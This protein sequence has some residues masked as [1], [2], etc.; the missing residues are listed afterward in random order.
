MP[1]WI[2]LILSLFMLAM[3]VAGIAYAALHGF[4]ALNGIAEIGSRLGKPLSELADVP[5]GADA[6]EPLAPPTFTQPLNSTIS[7][8]DD[9]QVDVIRR[10]NAKRERHARAWARWSRFNR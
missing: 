6:R 8:Y 5:Q 2:W 4:R 7:R 1:W 10:R 3:I 9:A